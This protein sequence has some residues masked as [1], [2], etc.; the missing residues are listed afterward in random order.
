[1]YYAYTYPSTGSP[2]WLK[3][4]YTSGSVS[5]IARSFSQSHFCRQPGA[6]PHPRSQ[7]YLEILPWWYHLLFLLFLLLTLSSLL[8]PICLHPSTSDNYFI[9]PWGSVSPQGP[10]SVLSSSVVSRVGCQRLGTWCLEL[11]LVHHLPSGVS[12]FTQ[13]D[14]HPGLVKSEH[15]SSVSACP[16]H[17]NSGGTR[18]F[19]HSLFPLHP[20]PHTSLFLDF[21]DKKKDVCRRYTTCN[22]V[23]CIQICL[24]FQ[25]LKLRFNSFSHS[26]NHTLGQHGTWCF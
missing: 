16:E 23:L 9:W 10:Y 20:Q 24:Y 19:S 21:F 12:G 11:P 14:T 13:P 4:V 2:V 5:S 18:V 15:Q 6:S 22:F 8:S 17:W 26:N 7:V 25:S 1:M 3:E